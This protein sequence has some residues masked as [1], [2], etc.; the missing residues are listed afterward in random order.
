VAHCQA[1]RQAGTLE[2]QATQLQAR[3]RFL[4]GSRRLMYVCAATQHSLL[5]QLDWI[6]H[7]L[8]DVCASRRAPD[9][10]Y[11]CDICY[12]KT[13]RT[14]F[15]GF[16]SCIVKLDNLASGK[17][18]RLVELTDLVSLTDMTHLGSV[19]LD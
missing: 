4:E 6:V 14:R 11:N 3:A 19:I 2:L 8:C 5:S 18:A 9:Q 1:G 16:V 17:D 13:T 10:A 7:V 15:W 12:N